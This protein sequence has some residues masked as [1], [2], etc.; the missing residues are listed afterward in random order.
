MHIPS[1]EKCPY[2]TEKMVTVGI[3]SFPKKGFA[4]KTGKARYCTKE[5]MTKPIEGW[6]MIHYQY[7]EIDGEKR[8]NEKAIIP[9]S[10]PYILEH[11]IVNQ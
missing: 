1:C 3:G 2:S 7:I 4:L 9:D 6:E 10:C 11:T 8:V 5:K